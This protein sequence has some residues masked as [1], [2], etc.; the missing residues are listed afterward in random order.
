MATKTP[1][2]KKEEIKEK[3]YVIPLREKCRSVPRYRKT[4]KAIKTIKEFI[5][6]HMKI[7]DRDLKK[8]KIDSYL[9]E[10]VWFNGIKNPPHKIK[11]KAIKEGEIVRVEAAE[12]IGKID[13]KK[14]KADKEI[15]AAEETVK[16]KLAEKKAA[17]EAAKKEEESKSEEE[18][19][20]EAEKKTVEKE[21]AFSG[22][23]AAQKVAETQAKQIKKAK[24]PKMKEPKRPQ[25][26]AL[27]K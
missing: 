11:V 18:K 5:V 6:R 2:K 7:R 21:K 8:V 15:K 22:A 3:I 27:A 26:K 23:E 17:E 14:K 25:R 12:L 19:K 10:M 9:N 24:Q 20:E 1:Q 13:F 4:E 16:K